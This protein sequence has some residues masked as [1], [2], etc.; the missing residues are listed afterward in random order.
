VLTLE[1]AC[2]GDARAALDEVPP[3]EAAGIVSA[4]TGR[5]IAART[6]LV[7]SELVY[8]FRPGDRLHSLADALPVLLRLAEAASAPARPPEM[9]LAGRRLGIALGALAE[10]L[11]RDILRRPD[12]GV[13]ETFRA[14]ADDHDPGRAGGASSGGDH[15]E[16]RGGASWTSR[17]PST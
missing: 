10:T 11:A 12:L 7:Q 2:G 15:P 6:D 1:T 16:P 14:Y 4:L 8:Y 9:R 3:A 17:P 13:A 5:V